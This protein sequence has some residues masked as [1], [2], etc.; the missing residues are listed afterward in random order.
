MGKRSEGRHFRCRFLARE[1]VHDDPEMEGLY[2]SGSTA[3]TGRLVDMRAV[4]HRYSILCLDAENAY[5][6]AEEDEDVHCWPP[7]EWVQRYHSRGG[8]VDNPWWKLKRQLYGR[9]KAAKKFKEF[10]VTATDG[11]GI[12]QC[13]EQPSL[14]RRP[15]T[16][17]IFECHHDDF[18]VSG[19]SVELPW[20]EENLGARPK[21]K[22]A[23]PLGPGSQY[24][25]LRRER[26]LTRT[27]T[28]PLETYIKNVLDILGLVDNKCKPMPTPIVQTRQK[29]DEDEPRLGE[30]DRRAY[31]RCVRHSQ[32]SLEVPTRQH[33]QSTRSARRSHPPELQKLGIKM[34]KES[35]DPEYLDAHRRRLEW[36]FNQQKEYFG[37]NTQDR[38]GNVEGVHEGSE[39]SNVIERRERA[40]RCGDD[41]SSGVA[42]RTTSGILGKVGE[43][44]IEN[45]FDSSPRHHPEARMRTSQAH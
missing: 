23:E 10:V 12:E 3:A 2:T 27:P 44:P 25:Y 15:G 26:G 21:L 18:Y 40:P 45:R 41:N 1:F 33:S 17:L 5:F 43:A 29:S 28:P 14:F 39:L 38:F 19:S 11:L 31:H 6:H 13:P 32:T 35:N 20:L 30:E 22:Q 4:Q 34:R 42:P 8:R 37:L 36:R 9:R 16:T 7:K 24:S